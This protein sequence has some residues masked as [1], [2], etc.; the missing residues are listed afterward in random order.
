M[1]IGRIAHIAFQVRD[2]ATSLEFYR[3]GLEMPEKF[4]VTYGE[5]LSQMA[6]DAADGRPHA[7]SA[8]VLAAFEAHRTDPWLVYVEVAS[9]QFLELFPAI[10]PGSLPDPL[11]VD[12]SSHFCLEVPDLEATHAELTRRGLAPEP[13]SRG[14][15]RSMQFWI[16]D[17]DGHRI[18]LMQYTSESLQLRLRAS[19]PTNH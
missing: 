5:L 12:V 16:T 18:E 19:A 3:D 13:I 4:R 10:T 17:P 6:A 14:V 2:L 1:S 8:R 7:A 15:D 9:G 11:V